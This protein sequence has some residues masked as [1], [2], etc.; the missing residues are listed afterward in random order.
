MKNG[1]VDQVVEQWSESAVALFYMLLFH[2]CLKQIERKT[3]SR[4][5]MFDLKTL[6]NLCNA[7]CKAS[8][9]RLSHA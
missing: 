8:H 9:N 6:L 1:S 2:Q 7:L 3:A 5:I 4:R